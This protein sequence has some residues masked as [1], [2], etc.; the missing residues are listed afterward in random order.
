MLKM[1]RIPYKKS[2]GNVE[3]EAGAQGLKGPPGQIC[4]Q[5]SM[6]FEVASGSASKMPSVRQLALRRS[7]TVVHTP[8]QCSLTLGRKSVLV[9]S[10]AVV[11]EG[12]VC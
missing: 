8:P 12:T 2:Y 3:G 6:W 5:N 10:V 9:F 1:F 4:V 7:M 11:A